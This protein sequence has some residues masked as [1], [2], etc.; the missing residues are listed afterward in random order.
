M[1]STCSLSEF[2]IAR[3]GLNVH[4]LNNRVARMVGSGGHEPEDMARPGMARGRG[5]STRQTNVTRVLDALR[6]DGPSSQAAL[7]RRTGLSRAT[8]NNIIKGL[9]V[10][11]VAE[12][13]PVNGRES[14]VTLASSQGAVVC[15]QIT[16]KSLRT[17]L[18]DFGRGARHDVVVRLGQDSPGGDPDA[19]IAMVRELIA[20]HGLTSAD[21][22][23][24]AVSVQGPLARVSGAI[25]SWARLDLPG[26]ENVPVADVLMKALDVPVIAENDANLAALAEWTWGAGRGSADFLYA[27]CSSRIGGG[28]VLDGRIYRGG[29]GLAG[30]IGHVVVAQNGPVCQ[31]GSRGC[32]TTFTS[33]RSILAMLEN[34]AGLSRQSL[35]EVID[36]ARNGDPAC[37]RVLFEAGR[38]LGSAFAN[39]A[40]VTAPS[41]IAIGGLLGA[42]GPLVFDGLNSSVE[43]N[44]MRAASP[45]IQLRPAEIGADA[46]LFG[47]VAALLDHLGLGVSTLPE[48]MKKPQTTVQ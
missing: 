15:V 39:I 37:V 24:V 34:G 1:S 32:L 30:E 46:T 38:Y 40:K 41:V 8:I 43:I 48:W 19:V 6:T 28:L 13:Q 11:G 2:R 18:F 23:G 44:S 33:E 22:T 36:S 47:G 4:Y 21:L 29:D 12:V 14:V 10:D 7:A 26:W 25:T 35:R 20:A 31:C 27:M 3:T 5:S 16:V 17:A 9:R 42:A 45:D